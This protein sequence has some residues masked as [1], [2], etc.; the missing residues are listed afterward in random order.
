[1]LVVADFTSSRVY[2]L[3]T[4]TAKRSYHF[5]RNDLL[6]SR[7]TATSARPPLNL[8][9]AL[10]THLDALHPTETTAQVMQAAAE[11]FALLAKSC[12]GG[13]TPQAAAQFLMRLPFCPFA[14]DSGLLPDKFFKGGNDAQG[15][16]ANR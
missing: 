4:N 3:F 12:A 9:R 1:L 11:K 16:W 2:P 7:L 15:R 10:F 8:L 6:D 14:E 13:V 5:D